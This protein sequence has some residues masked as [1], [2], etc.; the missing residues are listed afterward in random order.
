VAIEKLAWLVEELEPT[1][2]PRIVIVKALPRVMLAPD[3]VMTKV[4]IGVSVGPNIAAKLGTLLDTN[5]GV[6]PPA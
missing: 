5:D 3:V 1:Y 6:I 4:L 2:K